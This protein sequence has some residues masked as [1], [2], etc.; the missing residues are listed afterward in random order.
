MIQNTPDFPPFIVREAYATDMDGLLNMGRRFTDETSQ[1][2]ATFSARQT[3][4]T[5][6]KFLLSPESTILVV[7]RGEAML[8]GTMLA[9]QAQFTEELFGYVVKFFVAPGARGSG[10]SRALLAA[11]MEWFAEKRC[12]YVFATAAA[13]ISPKQDR[14]FENLFAKFGFAS[15]G[16]TMMRK[17]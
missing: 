10:A 13:A 16:A 7:Q 4:N 11:S 15:L 5:M 9:A 17:I 8:A 6:S 3:K 12:R 1:Y 14:E 2:G